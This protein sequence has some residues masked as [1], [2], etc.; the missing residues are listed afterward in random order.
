MD[1]PLARTPLASRRSPRRPCARKHSSAVGPHRSRRL[2]SCPI[3]RAAQSRWL[4]VTHRVADRA[5]VKPQRKP[6][7]RSWGHNLLESPINSREGAPVFPS[8]PF[9]SCPRFLLQ[10]AELKRHRT[11]PLTAPPLLTPAYP[12]RRRTAPPPYAATLR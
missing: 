7:R 11:P 8:A 6:W 5:A 3:R 2:G 9:F 4:S 10:R 1:V 12:R